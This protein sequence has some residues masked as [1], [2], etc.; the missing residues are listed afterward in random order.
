MTFKYE[1]RGWWPSSER[2]DSPP[3]TPLYSVLRFIVRSH[4]GLRLSGSDL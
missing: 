1:G 3:Q 2:I 4:H